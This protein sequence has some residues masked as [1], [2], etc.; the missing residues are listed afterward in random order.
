MLSLQLPGKNN[1]SIRIE[2]DTHQTLEDLRI[3]RGQFGQAD[4]LE[5]LTKDFKEFGAGGATQAV[6]SREIQATRAIDLRTG[7]VIYETE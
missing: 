4:W 1:A 2:F 6:T 3:P 7:K 5:P